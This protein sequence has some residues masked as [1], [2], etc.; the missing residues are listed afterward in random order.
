MRPAA[1]ALVLAGLLALAACSN[2]GP[3][4]RIKQPVLTGGSLVVLVYGNT[5]RARSEAGHRFDIYYREDGQVFLR[6][7]RRD[8]YVLA[9]QGIWSV[10]ADRL[11]TRW[12][13]LRGRT[14]ICEWVTLQADVF[15]TYDP[16]GNPTA[17]GTI[18]EGITESV[19]TALQ[20]TES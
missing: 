12:Q 5:F 4:T 6:G 8:G 3:G 14:K 10:E 17:T 1:R 11:C 19:K 9:D 13:R 15:K 16:A 2:F 20:A 7:K 18:L